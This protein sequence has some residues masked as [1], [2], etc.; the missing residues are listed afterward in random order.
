NCKS[1]GYEL[2]DN[3]K[4]CPECGAPRPHQEICT[5]CGYPLPDGVKFCPECGA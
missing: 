5:A 1:C 3:V 2:P 4:F